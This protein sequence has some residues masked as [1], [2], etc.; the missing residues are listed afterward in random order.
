MVQIHADAIHYSYPV[1]EHMRSL[2]ISI[3]QSVVGGAIR[4]DGAKTY[5]NALNDVSFTLNPGDRL[6][7][8]GHNGSGKTT[9]LRLLAGLIVPD[10]GTLTIEG[11]VLSLI[12]RGTG[13]NED[14][15][16]RANIELP[17]RMLG[18]TD[19]EVE[20]AKIEIPE[21]VDLGSFFDLPV[22]TYS[23]GMKA[24]LTFGICTFLR[25]DVIL[26][27]EWLSAG[28]KDFLDKANARM[29]DMVSGTGI[30][31]MATHATDLITSVCNRVAIM[32]SGRMKMIGT[33]EEAL[34]VYDPNA[35]TT[36]QPL[37]LV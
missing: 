4:R 28:D 15:T 18:A 19:A 25:G 3:M 11:R 24:R 17:L 21:F 5:V 35:P 33:P 29:A 23:E 10:R 32:E 36:D 7:L 22:R 2:K 31:V 37:S 26:L 20:R 14:L 34:A 1:L 16:G 12:S 9:L 6:G 30:L 8:L 27:D 13:I